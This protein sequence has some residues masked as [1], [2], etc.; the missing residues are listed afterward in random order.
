MECIK[1]K[2]RQR[3]LVMLSLLLTAAATMIPK[4]SSE[5][6]KRSINGQIMV[7]ITVIMS[8]DVINDFC[9]SSILTY[10]KCLMLI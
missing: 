4:S 6:L 3:R 7:S 5:A 1:L 10:L 2:Q 9:L 8:N